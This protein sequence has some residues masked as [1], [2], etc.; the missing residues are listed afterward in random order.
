MELIKLIVREKQLEILKH[1]DKVKSIA[2]LNKKVDITYS[3]LTKIMHLYQKAG[4]IET[5]KVGR[6]RVLNLTE[7]GEKLCGA[8]LNI[9][10]VLK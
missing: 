6:V 5:R 9:I 2:E 8:I 4:I 10:Q 7:K 1:L 3:H